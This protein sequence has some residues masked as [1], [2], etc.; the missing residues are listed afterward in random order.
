[1]KIQMSVRFANRPTELRPADFCICSHDWN[2][3]SMNMEEFRQKPGWREDGLDFVE[4]LVPDP[5]DV[6]SLIIHFPQQLAFAKTP[7]FEVYEP[8]TGFD[9]KR[10]D[11]LTAQYEHCFYYSILLREAVLFVPHPPAP[12]SY[13][14]SWLIGESHIDATSP[15]IPLQRQRQRDFAKKMLHMRRMLTAKP[16]IRRLPANSK[17]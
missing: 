16:G 14:I 10:I 4:K 9:E 3:F 7:F 12:F 2:V 1:M 17:F 6:F 13:R 15:L 8:S 5:W 11:D